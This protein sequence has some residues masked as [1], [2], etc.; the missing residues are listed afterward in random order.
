[1][2]DVMKIDVVDNA[3]LVVKTTKIRTHLNKLL[4]DNLSTYLNRLNQ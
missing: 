2:V 3:S 4:S 1:M